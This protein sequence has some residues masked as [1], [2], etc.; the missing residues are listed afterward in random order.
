M[1]WVKG[2]YRQPSLIYV[3]F[4]DNQRGSLVWQ[5]YVDTFVDG[6]PERGGET[7]P[8]GLY[9]PIRGFGKVWR[10]H[11]EVRNTLGWAVAPEA[12]DQGT[13]QD[14]QGGKRMLYRST[15]GRV[16]VL[17]PDGHAEDVALS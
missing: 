15:Q 12:A 6:Q 5:S 13:V 14:F 16:F 7:P 1:V 4:Y 10:E 9:E 11:P 17:Y 2:G 3:L 8:A